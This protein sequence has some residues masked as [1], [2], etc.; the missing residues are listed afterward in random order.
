[1]NAPQQNFDGLLPPGPCVA[2]RL[3]GHYDFRGES[4]QPGYLRSSGI[5]ASRPLTE[6]YSGAVRT[7]LMTSD[8]FGGEP[9]RCFMPGLGFTIGDG[10]DAVEILVCLQCYWIY[11]FRGET[12]MTETLS[13]AGQHR[14]SALYIELFPDGNPRAA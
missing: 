11:F 9:A 4:S 6:D 14:L 7:I 12:R 2:Y 3:N 13:K 5:L 1:M 8:S 10:A